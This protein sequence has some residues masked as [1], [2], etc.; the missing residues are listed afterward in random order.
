M[1]KRLCKV[2]RNIEFVDAMQIKD[3]ERDLF[4]KKNEW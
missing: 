4:K 1:L 3:F 2:K